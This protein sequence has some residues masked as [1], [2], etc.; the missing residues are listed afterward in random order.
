MTDADVNVK[1]ALIA[2]GVLG[3]IAL[4]FLMLYV[5]IPAAL[6]A[7]VIDFG[8]RQSYNSKL[9]KVQSSKELTIAPAIHSFDARI[10]D[11]QIVA[12]WLVDLPGDAL[13]DIY[14]VTGHGGGSIDEL[15]A[16]GDCIHTTGLELTDSRDQ[17]FVDVGLP[18]G[19]YYYV[20][21]VSG[22]VIEKEPLPYSLFD[23][24]KDVQF[25]TRRTRLAMRGEAVAVVVAAE[26]VAQIPDL[27]DEPSKIADDV[28]AH[29]RSRRK[30]D[31]DLDAAI[32]RINDSGELSEEEKQEAI[33]LLET[34]ATAK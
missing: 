4:G 33:E 9:A 29:I 19:T 6:I 31:A 12:G 2:A 21:V 10:V 8:M 30:F 17:L 13:L 15:N 22:L 20:P 5:V 1:L 26:V 24:A 27:R 32:S 11:G 14:R 23:F 18:D 28:M 3:V 16:R 25:R 7:G 34:R